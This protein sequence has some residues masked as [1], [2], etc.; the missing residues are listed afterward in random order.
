[1]ESAPRRGS[2]PR[3]SE[4][5]VGS[6][7]VSPVG[8]GEVRE[9]TPSRSGTPQRP[10]PGSNRPQ[11]LRERIEEQRRRLKTDPQICGIVDRQVAMLGT[12]RRKRQ[13]KCDGDI[14][15]D[16]S[17]I[18]RPGSAM[19]NSD[20]LINPTG[21]PAR[22]V[23]RS[24]T[25]AVERT[26]F[27]VTPQSRIPPLLRSRVPVPALE[28][29][30]CG[31]DSYSYEETQAQS[32]PNH[33]KSIDKRHTRARLLAPSAALKKKKDILVAK[34]RSALEPTRSIAL[35]IEHVLQQQRP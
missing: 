20:I 11:T 33:E 13:P 6:R 29:V 1:M 22:V 21:S 14:S 8:E 10:R 31:N 5:S 9:T 27:V 30:Y 2:P 16:R 19:S 35:R 17:T 18:V 7:T 34:E 15:V 25:P 24:F 32:Q 3:D 4:H 12:L 23:T 28:D 26:R